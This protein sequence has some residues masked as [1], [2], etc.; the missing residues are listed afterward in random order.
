MDKKRIVV[1]SGFIVIF[2]ISIIMS[3]I[4]YNDKYSVSFE[5]GTDE[6]IL[7]Q[8]VEKNETVNEPYEPTK[9]G[10]IFK[11]WQLNGEPY[12]FDTKIKQDTILTAKWIKEEYVIVN[13]DTDSNYE[14][15]SKKI[16]KGDKIDELPTSEKDDYEF[17]GWYLKEDFYNQE[18]IYSDVVLSAQYKNEK[19]NT[20]YKIGDRVKIIGNYSKSAYSKNAYNKKAIGWEREILNIIDGSEYPYVIGNKSGVTGYFKASSIEIIGK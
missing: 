14:I 17:I 10:Y 8:Y 6:N 19:L 2:I 18:L 16:L 7:T 11:E 9:D 4:Y 12:N 3:L 1:I 15:D 13:F 5:T 20:T